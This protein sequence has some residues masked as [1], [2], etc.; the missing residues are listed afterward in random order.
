MTLVFIDITALF[1]NEEEGVCDKSLCGEVSCWS[2]LPYLHTEYLRSSCRP[3]IVVYLN[4]DAVAIAFCIG[5]CG[6]P[7]R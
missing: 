2:M 4:I 3:F 7:R 6:L 1:A 5:T